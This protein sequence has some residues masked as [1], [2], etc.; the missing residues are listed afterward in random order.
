MGRRAE[1]ADVP[2]KQLHIARRATTR[3]KEQFHMK[4][5][6]KSLGAAEGRTRIAEF[7][8]LSAN[9]HTNLAYLEEKMAGTI[10]GINALWLVAV[11]YAW[12]RGEQYVT[13]FWNIR[14]FPPPTHPGDLT[15]KNPSKSCDKP[16]RPNPTG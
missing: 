5:K 3:K 10:A 14:T 2:E 9:H 12:W 8:V 13:V 1:S 6:V 15:L 7:V 16:L 11:A 4:K